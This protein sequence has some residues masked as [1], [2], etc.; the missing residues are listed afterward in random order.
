MFLPKLH[1]FYL[2]S[3]ENIENLFLQ[4]KSISFKDNFPTNKSLNIANESSENTARLRKLQEIVDTAPILKL[5][6]QRKLE[7]L[8][9]FTNLV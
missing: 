4:N 8:L 7:F 9:E 2:K 5:K 6:V 1:H 3:N